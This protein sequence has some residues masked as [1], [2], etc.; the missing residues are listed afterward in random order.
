MASMSKV[1]RKIISAEIIL[2][3]GCVVLSMF[4]IYLGFLC[5]LY[6]PDCQYVVRVNCCVKDDLGLTCNSA[7]MIDR[8]ILGV[9]HL[10]AKPMYRNLKKDNI[11]SHGQVPE[12][13]PSWY[14]TPFDPRPVTSS[15]RAARPLYT[16]L[17]ISCSVQMIA[18]YRPTMHARQS[19]IVRGLFPLLADPHLN[20]NGKTPA[21]VPPAKL[22]VHQPSPHLVD[23]NP[24]T[25]FKKRATIVANS[26]ISS[27]DLLFLE[28]GEIG[29]YDSTRVTSA[30][31]EE[32]F[33]KIAALGGQS[34]TSVNVNVFS[35]F[36]DRLKEIRELPVMLILLLA[37]LN[38]FSKRSLPLNVLGSNRNYSKYY[39]VVVQYTAR[40]NAEIVKNFLYALNNGKISKKKFNYKYNNCQ[41]YGDDS[42]FL[43]RPNH[44]VRLAPEEASAKLTGYEHNGVTC[45]GMKADIPVILDES[46][47]K[48][49]PDFFWLG[50]GEIDHKLGIRTSE[51]IDYVKP[52]IIN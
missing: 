6:V 3:N 8:Y 45:I 52:F 27:A 38:K 2:G 24:G 21:G 34:A 4:V 5:G 42:E 33:D 41:F 11:S 37:R 26:K 47:V 16:I 30:P 49:K 44:A 43:T 22:D 48:L 1:E 31:C 15:G 10:Y 32:V 51:F 35:A 12:T 36:Y 19:L 40:F 23:A 28:Q 46:I 20:K 7:G 50:S 13:S 39:V 25:N 14:H 17:L 18:K 29:R 9:E